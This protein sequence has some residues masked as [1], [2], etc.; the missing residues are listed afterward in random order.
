MHKQKDFLIIITNLMPW[1]F[2]LLPE[3]LFNV[4][5]NIKVKKLQFYLV[6]IMK[7]GDLTSDGRGR[8]KK[9]KS[10]TVDT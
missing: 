5:V 6:D 3:S 10:Q 8:V 2:G 1:D 7:I 9:K 4:E